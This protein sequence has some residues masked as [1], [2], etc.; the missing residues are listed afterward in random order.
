VHQAILLYCFICTTYHE[1]ANLAQDKS[2]RLDNLIA[3][4][5]KAAQPNQK[6]LTNII[7]FQSPTDKKR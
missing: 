1:S 5:F 3:K 7:E 2:P 4:D 6:W